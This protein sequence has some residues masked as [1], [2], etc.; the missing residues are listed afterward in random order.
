MRSA[1]SMSTSASTPSPSPS[2]S[3]PASPSSIPFHPRADNHKQEM[4]DKLLRVDHAGEYGAVRIY[5]GQMAVLGHSQVGKTLEEMH[6]QEQVHLTNLQRVMPQRRVR[7]TA[8]LPLWHV[9][10]YALGAGTAL[11]GKEA[12]MACTVAVEE[13]IV[14]HYNNQLRDLHEQSQVSGN[15]ENEDIRKM[16]VKHRDE[17]LE[18]RDIGI[19]HN[20]LQAPMYQALSA[21]IKTGC[22]VAIWAS[23]RV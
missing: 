13:V 19:E 21:V 14:E 10:G 23:E 7:P 8:L 12:A 2:P 16:I 1:M 6:R 22:R 18:H 3:A 11:L 15:K 17:E 9:A 5:Q 20:A 4:M